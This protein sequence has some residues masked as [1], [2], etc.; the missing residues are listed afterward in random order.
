MIG[1]CS[2]LC[3]ERDLRPGERSVNGFFRPGIRKGNIY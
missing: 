3:E 1:L 2:L